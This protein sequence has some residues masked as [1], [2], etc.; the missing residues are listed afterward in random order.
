MARRLAELLDEG[1]SL[2][3]PLDSPEELLSAV[4]QALEDIEPRGNVFLLLVGAWRDLIVSLALRS[5]EGYMSG[6]E[7]PE[8]R[9]VGEEAR[10][11]GYPMIWVPGG[12]ELYVVEPGG[13]GCVLRAQFDGDRDSGFEGNDHSSS[14]RH[15][16]P[17]RTPTTFP[18]TGA[19]ETA[20]A[21]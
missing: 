18:R 10:Y 3:A 17:G 6:W 15:E 16:A 9:Q 21:R 12:N 8:A 4:D 7:V 14:T 19:G 1:P 13:W 5:P 11:R 2:V 20:K